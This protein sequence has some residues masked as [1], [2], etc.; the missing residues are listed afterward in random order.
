[1]SKTLTEIAQQLKNANKKVQLIY[2]FNG[3]GKRA[4]RESLSSMLP[5]RMMG[6]KSNNLNHHATSFC[7]TTLLLKIYS[8]GTMIWS[9][10]PSPG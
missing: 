6:M 4:C 2:A 3:T 7:I 9:R 1:M 8:I 10:M 5:P